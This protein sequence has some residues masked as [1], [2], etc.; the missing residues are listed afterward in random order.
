MPSPGAA[1][2]ALPLGSQPSSS[3]QGNLRA[4][5]HPE[6]LRSRPPGQPSPQPSPTESHSQPTKPK[7]ASGWVQGTSA[8]FNYREALGH[9]GEE[10]HRARQLLARSQR[11]HKTGF[12]ALESFRMGHK[13]GTTAQVLPKQGTDAAADIP[14]IPLGL[15]VSPPAWPRGAGRRTPCPHGQWGAGRGHPKPRASPYLSTARLLRAA[16]TR[17]GQ[18]ASAGTRWPPSH[19]VC[20]AGLPP[21][22]ESGRAQHPAAQ[23][24]CSRGKTPS[25][26]L[27]LERDPPG[28]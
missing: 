11:P 23:E 21:A 17:P 9:R 15:E 18:Y 27:P 28:C 13:R 3:S 5:P 19:V 7:P 12:R 26:E 20:L 24:L 14:A 25:P 4:R 10:A 6:L 8:A 2:P 16:G 22:G 1:A